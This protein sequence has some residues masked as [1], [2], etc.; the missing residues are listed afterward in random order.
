MNLQTLYKTSSKL[1]NN[2]MYFCTGPVAVSALLIGDLQITKG[3]NDYSRQAQETVGQKSSA[4]VLVN[5]CKR[6]LE[7]NLPYWFLW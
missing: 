7:T 1:I 5:K 4:H 6:E 2:G 3:Y